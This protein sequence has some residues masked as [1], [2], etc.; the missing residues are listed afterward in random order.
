[1]L[2]SASTG[3]AS[4]TSTPP[5]TFINLSNFKLT[6]PVNSRG[7]STGKAD[8]VDNGTL[9]GSP[10]YSSSYFYSDTAGT[11]VFYAPSNGATTSPGSGGD[12]TRSELRELYRPSGPTEW[13]N[14][15]GGTMNASCQVNKVA[16]KSAKAIIGQIH[17]LDSI[18]VLVY[19]DIGK[20]TVEAKFYTKP[21]S[22]AATAFVVASNVKLGDRID[23]QIQ[24][25][26][27][28]ASVTVNGRTINRVPGAAWNKV[29]VYFKAGAYSSSPNKSNAA[30]DATEVAF[31]SLQL[32]H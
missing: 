2:F 8:E 26:G 5:K 21:G 4:R 28:T 19:Y 27:S 6:L 30:G 12:H 25:I 9:N 7:G 31:Y 18:F 13:T 15:I 3:A 14:N 1:M 10:G 16:K 22:D 23:Y 24:W 11:V 29:P 32:Q 17:G 20:K